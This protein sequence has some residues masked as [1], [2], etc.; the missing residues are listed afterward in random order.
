MINNSDHPETGSAHSGSAHSGSAHSSSAR[1]G[2]ARPGEAMGGIVA[3]Q[4]WLAGVTALLGILAGAG[5]AAVAPPSYLAR[6]YV[7]VVTQEREDTAAV[8]LAQA[9][10]RIA[11]NADVIVAIAGPNPVAA[12]PIAPTPAASS[13]AARQTG[14]AATPP[15]AQSPDL[16]PS[17]A[18]SPA[19]ASPTAG[20]TATVATP[21]PGA[22][23]V[24]ASATELR[25]QVTATTSPDAPV[26]EVTG[27]DENPRRA[28]DLANL[29]AESLIAY[30]SGSAAQA[31][32]RVVLL[33]PAYPPADP[34]SPRPGLSIAVGAAAGLL[35]GAFAV[36]A[37]FGRRPPGTRWVVRR[38]ARTGRVEAARHSDGRPPGGQPPRVTKDDSER[39][40][41]R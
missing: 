14:A 1:A 22:T 20:Q 28:A 17:T 29:V 24:P 30:A 15:A 21:R 18:T 39:T 19:A 12:P 35:A 16:A 33:S 2:E 26:I 41:R 13:P 32:M 7:L 36:M 5:Y 3:R 11:A 38:H 25:R 34:A 37:G 9:Y 40:V 4:W 27:S 6:A 31:G 10:G 8:H 23:T